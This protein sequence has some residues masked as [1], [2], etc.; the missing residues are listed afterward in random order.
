MPDD[1]SLVGG[2]LLDRLLD[3]VGLTTPFR[4]AVAM[5]IVAWGGLFVIAWARGAATDGASLRLLLSDYPTY[6]RFL[7]AI[8]LFVFAEPVVAGRTSA[9][10][11]YIR[12]SGVVDT[13]DL[14][15][16]DWAAASAARAA[17]SAPIEV[18][19]LV[20]AYTSSIAVLGFV[21][22][23]VGPT[24]G[25]HFNEL[26]RSF[27]PVIWWYALVSLPIFT[28]LFYR[29]MARLL[30][31]AWF[32]WR[33]SRLK[34]SLIATHPDLAGGLGFLAVGQVAYWYIVFA[35][36]CVV[37]SILA[38]R[39]V[40]NREEISSFAVLIAV[41][42]VMSVLIVLGPL[43]VFVPELVRTKVS[44]TMEYGRLAGR[45]TQG[46]EHKWVAGPDPGEELLGTSDIQSLADIGNSYEVV[47]KMRI[48]PFG[49]SAVVVIAVAATAPLVP[50][51]F[52][53]FGGSEALARLFKMLF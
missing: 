1:F 4:R 7:V 12:S 16:V 9:V 25:T 6:A 17:R 23:V 53:Q 50:L 28:F 47:R 8:P 33:V 15:D 21:P 14:A 2:G 24:V 18:A 41:H 49:T 43:L 45:Y 34:L 26:A 20:L 22:Q 44:G 31:W 42:V 52:V 48:T 13:H 3:R 5:A 29:W 10:V 46:F 27:K 37:S 35:A 40:L 38:Q 51:L 11:S 19:V 39:I 32:L 36:G 30:V